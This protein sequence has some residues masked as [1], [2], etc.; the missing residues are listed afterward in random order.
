MPEGGV[1]QGAPLS[2]TIP[3][4]YIYPHDPV[5]R[6]CQFEA[7]F[8]EYI[9]W[10]GLA[11]DNY[12]HADFYYLPLF[13]QCRFAAAQGA[14]DSDRLAAVLRDHIVPYLDRIRT[15]YPVWNATYGHKHLAL[16]FMDRGIC[17]YWGQ[18]EFLKS[19]ENVTKV[20]FVGLLPH[21]PWAR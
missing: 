14:S 21:S 13:V 1:I 9:R 6:D 11:S 8:L 10:G 3:R 12:K 5:P 16:F 15:R 19:M 17:R 2:Q 18:W 4:I 7:T 20:G